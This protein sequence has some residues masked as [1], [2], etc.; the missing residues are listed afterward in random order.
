MEN[1]QVTPRHLVVRVTRVGVAWIVQ[2]VRRL[3][4]TLQLTCLQ[5]IALVIAVHM[6]FVLQKV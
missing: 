2:L 1:V 4:Y 6:D 5:L 3:W